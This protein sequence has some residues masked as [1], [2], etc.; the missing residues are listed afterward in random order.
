M[1]RLTPKLKR[2]ERFYN[3]KIW[4]NNRGVFWV[5]NDFLK[6][7]YHIPEKTK[8]IQLLVET[9]TS[10]TQL[11]KEAVR[12]ELQ[13]TSFWPHFRQKKGCYWSLM[14][15][16]MDKF[17]LDSFLKN[18]AQGLEIITLYVTVYLYT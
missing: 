11:S 6:K 18:K 14:Y 9:Q 10:S 4:V 16:A 7:N 15:N 12:V 17:L 3:E 13:R 2:E 5:C 8:K 1:K